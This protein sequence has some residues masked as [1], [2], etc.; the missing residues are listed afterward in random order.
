[1]ADR[2][3]TLSE[4]TEFHSFL[5]T[6]P[7]QDGV[8]IRTNPFP[9]I[10]L[11][12]PPQTGKSVLS[13]LLTEHLRQIRVPQSLLRAVPDDD[14]DW[15]YGGDREIFYRLCSYKKGD[16]STA[17]LDYIS[18]AIEKRWLPLLVDVS[19]KFQGDQLDLIDGC[20][21]SILLYRDDEDY[22]KWRDRLAGIGLQ[23][24]EELLSEPDAAD[25]IL[26]IRHVM[27][28]TIGGLKREI[29]N[30]R[31]GAIFGALLDRV[32][33]ISHYNALE[34]ERIHL[35][36]APLPALTE[37]GLADELGVPV[38]QK[39]FWEPWHLAQIEQRVSVGKPYAFYGHG[40]IW[41]T[42]MLAAYA[43]PA[44]YA[45][46]DARFGWLDVPPVRKGP[47]RNLKVMY[48]QRKGDL[49][50]DIKLSQQ[51]GLEPG[52]ISI[53]APLADVG[54]ILSGQLPAWVFAALTRFFAQTQAWVG[55]DDMDLDC[56]I[57]V[58]SKTVSHPVGRVLAHQ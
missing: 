25:K 29:E 9:A 43:W 46:F 2:P 23:T 8:N 50:L 45:V 56:V 20:T 21:H 33:G 13:Y 54:V 38:G 51:N 18:Q 31:V 48:S 24:V 17:F 58:W 32:A 35:I 53:S 27:R 3:V 14:G 30:R 5:N 22:L 19:G 37:R 12:G 6:Y 1:V 7:F 11:T 36:D 41:L 28:G 44:P 16:C 4:L 52:P 55:V 47:E 49:W 34:L 15:H 57:V 39:I 26:E 10:L 42:A 40:S